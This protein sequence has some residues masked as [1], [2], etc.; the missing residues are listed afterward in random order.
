MGRAV[1]D[2]EDQQLVVDALTAALAKSGTSQASFAAALGTSQPRLSTYINGRVM[3]SAALLVRA[4][5]LSEAL[6]RLRRLH[7]WSPVNTASAIRQVLV[8][9]PAFPARKVEREALRALLHG[10]DHLRLVLAEYPDLVLV[11]HARP[12]ATGRLEWDALLGAVTAHEFE[13]ADRAAPSWSQQT[14]LAHSWVYPS[15]LL[16]TSEVRAHTPAWLADCNLH[17]AERDLTT[18]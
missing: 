17:I 3:P 18:T 9:N 13:Q 15:A 10:R 11:W 14:H 8:G 1:G 4:Q 2:L 12:R 7:L 5:R 6:Q 16:S